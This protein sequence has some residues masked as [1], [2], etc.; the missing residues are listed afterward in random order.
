MSA[1]AVRDRLPERGVPAVAVGPP[2]T[3]VVGERVRPSEGT[4]WWRSIAAWAAIAPAGAQA[5]Y[6]LAKADGKVTRS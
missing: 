5:Y 1:V 3:P 6:L 4:P 2:A